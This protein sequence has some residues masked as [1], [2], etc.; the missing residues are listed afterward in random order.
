[1][2]DGHADI[3]DDSRLLRRVHPEQVIWDGNEQRLRPSTAAFRDFE[4]SVN[5]GSV[6][7]THGQPASHAVRNHPRHHLVAVTARFVRDE[8][9]QAIHPDPLEDDESHGN[10]VGGKPKPRRQRFALRAAWC[11]FRHDELKPELVGHAHSVT[12]DD[13]L[14]ET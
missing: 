14:N 3:P 9:E 8:E 11:I 4:L 5:L 7:A 13:A 6:M 1:M 2:T 12:V 10:V